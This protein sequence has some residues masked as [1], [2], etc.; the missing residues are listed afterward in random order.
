MCKSFD[1]T[2]EAFFVPTYKDAIVGIS[3]D[4][5]GGRII[6][7]YD[8]MLSCLMFYEDM[9]KEE[10]MQEIDTNV[11]PNLKDRNGSPI[12]MYSATAEDF[13]D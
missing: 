8:K 10:A 3:C 12:V 13:E 5:E 9:S 7:D 2:P 4:E 6:Y 1:S 11:L